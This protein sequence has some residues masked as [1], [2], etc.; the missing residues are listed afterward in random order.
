[1]NP[2]ASNRVFVAVLV[3][4]AVLGFSAEYGYYQAYGQNTF[5]NTAPVA[6]IAEGDRAI[7]AAG[8]WEAR[9]TLDAS[10]SFDADSAPRQTDGG[11]ASVKVVFFR[12]WFAVR[13]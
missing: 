8:M 7:D 13:R 4:A 6:C 10:C 5:A 12:R 9:V 1:M 11:Q 2:I 3:L